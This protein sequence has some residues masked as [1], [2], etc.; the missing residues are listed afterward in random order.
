[1]PL[2]QITEDL[3]CAGGRPCSSE[4]AEE[5][6]GTVE[7]PDEQAAK[8]LGAERYGLTEQRLALREMR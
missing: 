4:I 2:W 7:A 8:Q 3:S 5:S 6:L 1:M